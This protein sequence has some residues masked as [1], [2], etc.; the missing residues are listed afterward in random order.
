MQPKKSLGQN[1]LRDEKVLEKIIRSADLQLNDNVLEI[2]SGEGALTKELMKNI[3][4]IICIEKD[5]ALAKNLQTQYKDNEKVEIINDDI[6]EINLSEL[7]E[8]NN[9]QKYKIVANIPYYITSP[10]I[11]LFLETA[12]PPTEMFLMVQREVAER[13]SATAGQMSILSVSVQYYAQAEILFEVDRKC[14]WPVPEV[15]SAVIHIKPLTQPQPSHPYKGGSD[16]KTKDFFCLVKAGFSA[17]RKTLVNNLAASLQLDKKTTEEKLQK[18]GFAPTVR[19][20]ELS[21]A[22]WKKLA[23]LLHSKS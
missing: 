16:P 23:D 18:I 11:R 20:Q 19:A 13:M 17:K 8:K 1:F 5:D 22:D 10:I 9:F 6:L 4:K 2:G 3:G 7:I 12:Y 15:D 21:V 14:F